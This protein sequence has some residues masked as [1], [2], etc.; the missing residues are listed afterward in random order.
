MNEKSQNFLLIVLCCDFSFV[1]VGVEEVAEVFVLGDFAEFEAVHFAFN[2]GDDS[3][4]GFVG[5]FVFDHGFGDVLDFLEGESFHVDGVVGFIFVF[6]VADDA[7]TSLPI[8]FDAFLPHLRHFT[9][10]F[11]LF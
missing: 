3:H 2:V 5:F 10:K 9:I 7:G 8:I 4:V 11:I 1:L 6:E